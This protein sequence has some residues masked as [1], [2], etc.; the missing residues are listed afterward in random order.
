[1][2]RTSLSLFAVSLIFSAP[3]LG[4]ACA[5]VATDV[6]GTGGAATATGGAGTGGTVVATGGSQTGT[7]GTSTGGTST[8]GTSTGGTGTGGT[9]TGGTSTG[10]ASTGGTSTGGTS[11]DPDFDGQCAGM[12]THAEW[13][14]LSEQEKMSQPQAVFECDKLQAECN[15]LMAGTPYLFECTES[16]L[17][18]CNQS[19][20][21]GSSWTFVGECTAGM[22]GAGGN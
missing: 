1:M 7:G 3:A 22:G 6:G 18:N 16:H 8:G 20:S 15:G 9:S 13:T 21:D 2:A 4:G 19:P 5:E 11:G 12:P 17:P 10:G 14:G